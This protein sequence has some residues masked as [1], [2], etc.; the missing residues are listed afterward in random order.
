MF[1]IWS[2]IMTEQI[3]VKFI[4]IRCCFFISKKKVCFS[5]YSLSYSV[6]QF[7]RLENLCHNKIVESLYFVIIKTSCKVVIRGIFTLWFCYWLLL[8][9]ITQF[10][11]FCFCSVWYSITFLFLLLL[12]RALDFNILYSTNLNLN[13]GAGIR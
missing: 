1:V 2:L 4:S 3:F 12:L 5:Y 8:G 10:T 11:L 6:Q 13:L 7:L 9:L